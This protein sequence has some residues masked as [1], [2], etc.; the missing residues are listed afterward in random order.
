MEIEFARQDGA[1][2]V[3]SELME[4]AF[5]R[6]LARDGVIAQSETQARSFWSIRESI[7]LAERAFGKAIKHDVS[8]AVSDVGDFLLLAGEAVAQIVEGAVVFAFGHAGDGNIHYNIAA[9]VGENDEA[10]VA[11]YGET[12][13]RVVH[14]IICD[15]VDQSQPSTVSACKSVT[16]WPRA[17]A[18]S[19]WTCS[20]LSNA[21]WIRKTA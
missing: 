16:I 5:E 2:T 19:N 10:F 3:V 7:P 21:R 6:G 14:D 9:P 17:S 11:E 4:Q 20:R 8:T 13:T 15:L 18:P 1:E 12:V